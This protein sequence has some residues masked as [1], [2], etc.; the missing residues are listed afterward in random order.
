MSGI[1]ARLV[2]QEAQK[3]AAY[4]ATEPNGLDGFVA[5]FTAAVEWA[6]ERLSASAG[7]ADTSDPENASESGAQAQ[8]QPVSERACGAVGPNGA[9]R[10]G[11][12]HIGLHSLMDATTEPWVDEPASQRFHERTG[13]C[14]EA[15]HIV[16]SAIQDA[17]DAGEHSRCLAAECVDSRRSTCANRCQMG[18]ACT[19]RCRLLPYEAVLDSDGSMGGSFVEPEQANPPKDYVGLIHATRENLERSALLMPPNQGSL[20]EQFVRSMDPADIRAEAEAEFAREVAYKQSL[21]QH[22]TVLTNSLGVR[23]CSDCN[24]MLP[25]LP[26]TIE[27]RLARLEEQVATL[28][29]RPQFD[30][31]MLD[32]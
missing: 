25:R 9:C 17:H 24:Q 21:C 27:Q 19:G 22:R 4:W 23:I 30:Y 15:S 14:L 8:E 1:D 11:K 31:R 16:C 6:Q 10:K 3:Q 12:G 18:D 32:R 20:G 28:L 29:A 26:E 7:S 2:E 5:G 13:R